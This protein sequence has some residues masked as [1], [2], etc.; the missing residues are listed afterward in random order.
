MHDIIAG[1]D[2]RS[3]DQFPRIS[4]RY[5]IAGLNLH[6]SP[7]NPKLLSRHKPIEVEAQVLDLSVA[8][9]LL[10][11]PVNDKLRTGLRIPVRVGNAVG[12]VEVR[13]IRKSSVSGMAF[14]G[15]VFV[16]MSDR[17]V[18]NVNAVV[19]KLRSVKDPNIRIAQKSVLRSVQQAPSL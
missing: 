13:N 9:V 18:E 14:Y 6:W 5:R 8:G 1:D 3:P 4:E 12:T 19:A 2:A 16:K 15:V 7:P 17:L 10:M 11:A